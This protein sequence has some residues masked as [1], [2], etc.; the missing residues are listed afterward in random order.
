MNNFTEDLRTLI[1]NL[2]IGA[3]DLELYPMEESRLVEN[4]YEAGKF[5]ERAYEEAYSAKLRICK[6]LGIDEDD[7]LETIINNLLDIGKHLSLKMFDYG[8]L[9]SSPSS[10]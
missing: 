9:F 1:Y 4:E 3:Y 8:A 7:D 10:R 6:R 2:M 5:C